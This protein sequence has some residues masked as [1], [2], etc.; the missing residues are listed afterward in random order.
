MDRS[1]RVLVTGGIAVA[2]MLAAAGHGRF[3]HAKDAGARF[4]PSVRPT[5]VSR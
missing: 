4:D 3:A 2:F 1:W 5:T